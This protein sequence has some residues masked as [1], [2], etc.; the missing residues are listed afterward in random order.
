[1][2]TIVGLFYLAAGLAVVAWWSGIGYLMY[3]AIK[4]LQQHTS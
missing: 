2:R 1:V 4:Y 3:L